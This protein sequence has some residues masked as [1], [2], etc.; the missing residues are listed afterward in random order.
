MSFF[1]LR[2]NRANDEHN[3][4]GSSPSQSIESLRR[5]ARHR[6]IGATILVLL[7]VIGFP[8]LFDTQPRPV[9]GDIQIEIADKDKVKPADAP[10]TIKTSGSKGSA[11][12]VPNNASSDVASSVSPGGEKEAAQ[13]EKSKEHM[14]LLQSA[15]VAAG[16][17]VVGATVTAAT[18][19]SSVSNNSGASSAS[20]KTLAAESK[21]TKEPQEV[22]ISTKAPQS[23]G[24]A[25]VSSG[26][27]SAGAQ[28]VNSSRDAKENSKEGSKEMGKES[29]KE[30]AKEAVKENSKEVAK[31]AKDVKESKEAKESK[32]PKDAK[33]VKQMVQVGIYTDVGKVKEYTN[34]L[35]K[36][37]YKVTAHSVPGKDGS[38]RV[39]IRVGPYKNKDDALH[40][41]DKLK[42][43]KIPGAQFNLIPLP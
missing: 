28:S 2:S 12:G 9:K 23:K 18:N 8:I 42:E 24:A 41:V 35:E 27:G 21:E 30:A 38:K 39:R 29:S 40:A 26:A 7:V 14:S 6:L 5:S 3:P 1:K 13:S 36:A 43:M 25:A 34:K 11:G 15:G 10:V 16:V 31:D 4:A 20:G 33:P 19:S 37:G 22:I 32:E 17:A